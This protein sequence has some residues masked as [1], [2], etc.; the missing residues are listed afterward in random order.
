MTKEKRDKR[1]LE[2]G[3]GAGRGPS[4][5]WTLSARPRKADEGSLFLDLSTDTLYAFEGGKWH[6]F[7][8]DVE[9]TAK[10]AEAEAE[11]VTETKVISREEKGKEAPAKPAKKTTTKK[12]TASE[13]EAK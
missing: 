1:G 13:K 12:K 7:G 2:R 6:V 11:K 5:A 3:I 10:A 8:E 9:Q 4:M